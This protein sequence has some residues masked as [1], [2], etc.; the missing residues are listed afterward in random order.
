MKKCFIFF[1]NLQSSY[2]NFDAS[3][4]RFVIVFLNNNSNLA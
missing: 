1:Q 4:M 3:T 2:S